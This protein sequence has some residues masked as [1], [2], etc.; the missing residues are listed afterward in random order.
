[1]EKLVYVS[2][3]PAIPETGQP[4]LQTEISEFSP[5]TVAGGHAKA[6]A[7]ATQAVL[8]AAANGLPA[9]VVH[10]SGIIRPYGEGRNH[11]VQMIRDFVEGRLPACVK[12]GYDLVDVRDVAA[13]CITAAEQDPVIISKGPRRIG[14]RPP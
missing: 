14:I 12:G 8:D 6:K 11:L 13:G 3:V 4:T 9:V 2:S 1:M 7:E 5:E 10:P